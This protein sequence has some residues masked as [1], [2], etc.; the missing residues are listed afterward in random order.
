VSTFTRACGAQ[1]SA[2]LLSQNQ[3]ELVYVAA[4]GNGFVPPVTRSLLQQAGAGGDSRTH[5]RRVEPAG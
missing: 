5:A 1:W 2:A 4:G 3:M